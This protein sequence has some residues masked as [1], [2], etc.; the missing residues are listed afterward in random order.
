MLPVPVTAIPPPGAPLSTSIRVPMSNDATPTPLPGGTVLLRNQNLEL[1]LE[2]HISRQE[3]RKLGT[4]KFPEGKRHFPRKF[5]GFVKIGQNQSVPRS[6]SH[7][8]IRLYI[9]V[10]IFN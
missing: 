7:S 8:E 5:P 2:W 9:D 6:L 10:H 4:R 3:N 1:Q